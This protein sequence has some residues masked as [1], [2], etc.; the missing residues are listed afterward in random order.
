MVL[1]GPLNLLGGERRQENLVAPH[2][3]E[4]GSTEAYDESAIERGTRVR[5]YFEK[6]V[7][8]FEGVVPTGPRAR[9]MVGLPLQVALPHP[10]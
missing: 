3:I 4:Q 2:G 7:R 10:S 1:V 9:E 8:A 6:F 5:R